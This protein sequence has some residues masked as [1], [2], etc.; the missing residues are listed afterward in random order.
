MN[1]VAA[2]VRNEGTAKHRSDLAKE[3]FERAFAHMRELAEI[4]AKS[5]AEA[6]EIVRKQADENIER[7]KNLGKPK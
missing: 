1:E 4:V 3:G 6:M 7:F 2:N 5:Q